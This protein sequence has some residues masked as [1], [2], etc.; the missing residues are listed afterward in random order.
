MAKTKKLRTL[1][2]KETLRNAQRMKSR[3][4]KMNQKGKTMRSLF[5]NGLAMREVFR[6]LRMITSKVRLT[7]LLKFKMKKSFLSLLISCQGLTL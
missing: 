4:K 5:K 7:S 2:L 3:R 6:A 1:I